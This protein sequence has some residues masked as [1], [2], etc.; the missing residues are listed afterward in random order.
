MT[1]QIYNRDSICTAQNEI[2][3]YVFDLFGEHLKNS[4]SKISYNKKRREFRWY[5][6][7]QLQA[8]IADGFVAGVE[9]MQGK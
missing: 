1:Q 3:D 4:C 8:V 7:R 6:N 9:S 2:N 5:L